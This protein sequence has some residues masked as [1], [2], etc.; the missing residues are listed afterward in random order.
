MQMPPALLL[1]GALTANGHHVNKSHRL[2]S[3]N[4]GMMLN[5]SLNRSLI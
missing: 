4:Q 2:L 5:I 1:F 3:P